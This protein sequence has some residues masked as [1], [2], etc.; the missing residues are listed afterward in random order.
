M[1]GIFAGFIAVYAA[2][3]HNPQLEFH[4]VESINFIGLGLIGLSWV[5]VVAVPVICLFY[6]LNFLVFK[7]NKPK[8]R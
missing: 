5:L 2:W 1:V 4:N 6:A 3:Q 8:N 7:L